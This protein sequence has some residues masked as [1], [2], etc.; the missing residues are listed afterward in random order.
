MTHVLIV[1]KEDMEVEVF[2][3]DGVGSNAAQED[4]MHGNGL[5]EDGQVLSEKERS[6]QVSQVTVPSVIS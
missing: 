5:L 2:P 6:T 1:L 3:Q 4:L